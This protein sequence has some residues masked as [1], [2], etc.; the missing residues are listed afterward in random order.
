MLTFFGRGGDWNNIINHKFIKQL[1]QNFTNAGTFPYD[2][3]SADNYFFPWS[4]GKVWDNIYLQ[5]PY[6]P[7]TISVK[8]LFFVSNAEIQPDW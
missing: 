7:D 1:I 6:S 2:K 8:F 3:A 4:F 5:S